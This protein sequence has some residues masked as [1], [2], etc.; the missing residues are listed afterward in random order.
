MKT[1][2]QK[3]FESA[4]WNILYTKPQCEKKVSEILSDKNILNF[5]P[6]KKTAAPWW[7]MKKTTEVPLF[8]SLIF[9][10]AVPEKLQEIKKISGVVNIMYWLGSPAVV[11]DEEINMLKGFLSSH[12]N[13][14]V[15]KTEIPFA[16]YDQ[17]SSDSLVHKLQVPVSY[18]QFQK[19]EIPTLGYRLISQD[20]TANNNVYQMNRQDGILVTEM[21]HA[22]SKAV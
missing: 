15:E 6:A 13:V 8:S 17:N 19:I 1:S 3:A 16:T 18:T 7:S 20:E 21:Q 11:T 4:A 9:F 10:K 22:Y 5:M 12:T 2:T 14:T